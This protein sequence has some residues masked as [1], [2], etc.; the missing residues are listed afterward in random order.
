MLFSRFEVE[1]SPQSGKMDATCRG[2]RKYL[3]ENL[4]L[5]V[6]RRLLYPG[7]RGFRERSG[8]AHS[9][10]GVPGLGFARVR[11]RQFAR[12]FAKIPGEELPRHV[13]TSVSQDRQRFAGTGE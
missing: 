1:W 4:L 10:Q 8:K 13:L 2:T 3:H 9:P 5:D 7:N 6:E 12:S 11:F